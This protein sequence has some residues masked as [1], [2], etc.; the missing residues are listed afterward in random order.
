MADR[1]A[2]TVRALSRRTLLAGSDPLFEV[3]DF[4][5]PVPGNRPSTVLT[6]VLGLGVQI[7]FHISHDGLP[8]TYIPPSA[9]SNRLE[10][11]QAERGED[12]QKRERVTYPFARVC[13]YAGVIGW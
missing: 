11:R 7:E 1:A 2:F 13:V 10:Q 6:L 4:T 8:S 12:K 3:L 9:G 5:E